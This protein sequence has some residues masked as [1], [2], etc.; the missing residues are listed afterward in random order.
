M[1]DEMAYIEREA[2]EQ[3]ESDY[4]ADMLA[5]GLCAECGGA[6]RVPAW[7]TGDTASGWADTCDECN[8]TGKDLRGCEWCNITHSVQKCPDVRA[9]LM[10]EGE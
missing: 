7:G 9:L 4:R 10:R 1:I 5:R 3:G 8:G 2:R 6:G